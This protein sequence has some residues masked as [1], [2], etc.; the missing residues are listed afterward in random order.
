ML[1]LVYFDV[2]ARGLGP[3][4]ALERG[5][6][7]WKRDPVPEGN[8]LKADRATYPFGQ[9]PILRDESNGIVVA[10]TVAIAN[11]IGRKTNTTGATEA[12]QALSDML[13]CEFETFYS[14]LGKSFSTANAKADPKLFAQRR[15]ID[16]P[17]QLSY[18]ED[19]LKA[20]G[21][22]GVFTPNAASVGESLLFS[23][24]H[25][26]VLCLPE[27]LAPF[28]TVKAWYDKVLAEPAVHKVLNGESPY[29]KFVQ[30]FCHP[31]EEELA[32]GTDQ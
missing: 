30:Y 28:A 5:G 15:D 3:A 19:I 4:L 17:A 23:V 6:A 32:P 24:I 31:T 22:D 1:T 9:L 11:Y 21:K 26:I 14:L 16:I 13:L 10:Q 25:Q 29:G 2:M 27:I 8:Q 7:E 20:R 12:E 18:L